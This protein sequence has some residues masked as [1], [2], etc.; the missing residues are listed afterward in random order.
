MAYI[1]RQSAFDTEKLFK[2]TD[3]GISDSETG[4]IRYGEVKK[5]QIRYKPTKHHRSFYQCDIIGKKGDC[6]RLVSRRYLGV[7]N[8]ANQTHEFKVFLTGLHQR[9]SA[10]PSIEFVAGL[11]K[12]R[13]YAELVVTSL[14][15]L[16][17]GW[18]IAFFS[19]GLGLILVGLIVWFRA[20][21]YFKRN[22]PRVYDPLHLPPDLLG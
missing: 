2:L 14:M 17:F 12:G 6:F 20:V 5:V 16:F 19:F 9:L 18:I 11:S 1:N 13:Y 3:T 4:I 15:A 10:Y 21:P 22:K 8:F 7:A